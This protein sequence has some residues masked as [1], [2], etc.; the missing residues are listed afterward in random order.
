MKRVFLYSSLLL[1]ITTE[2]LYKSSS[3]KSRFSQYLPYSK[4]PAVRHSARNRIWNFRLDVLL[5]K[6]IIILFRKVFGVDFSS[7]SSLFM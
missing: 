2:A 4:K 6:T 7:S 5:P 3:Y 1:L